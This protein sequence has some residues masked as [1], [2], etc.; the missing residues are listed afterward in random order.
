MKKWPVHKV[1]VKS[2]KNSQPV[3][4]LTSLAWATMSSIGLRRCHLW[5]RHWPRHPTRRPVLKVPI[6]GPCPSCFSLSLFLGRKVWINQEHSFLFVCQKI[7]TANQLEL[8]NYLISRTS[9]TL[10][11]QLSASMDK[12]CYTWILLIFRV[13][14]W[15][16][17]WSSYCG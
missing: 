9:S 8:L 6:S 15:D 16:N 11:S 13:S 17:K 5:W 7:E 10:I 1:F 14:W 12:R 3:T 4:Y 2:F